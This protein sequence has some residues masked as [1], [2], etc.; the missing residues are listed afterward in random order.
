[1]EQEQLR[2]DMEEVS[3]GKPQMV[4]AFGLRPHIRTIRIP[5]DVVDGILGPDTKV[6][7]VVK[8]VDLDV[9]RCLK[10]QE[11]THLERSLTL[12]SNEKLQYEI[13]YKLPKHLKKEIYLDYHPEAP[14]SG[15]STTSPPR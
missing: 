10:W 5:R 8:D 6:A 15:R 9:A 4:T 7:K 2:R 3:T 13:W 1:M 12:T 14:V 11:L